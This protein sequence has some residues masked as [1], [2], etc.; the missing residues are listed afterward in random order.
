MSEALTTIQKT[1]RAYHK[2]RV[3]FDQQRA[4]LEDAIRAGAEAG[5]SLRTI[6]TA[7]GIS[8]QRVQQ[9]LSRPVA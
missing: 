1:A 4:A 9:I 6:A 5:H 3:G 8:F 2:A 7:A